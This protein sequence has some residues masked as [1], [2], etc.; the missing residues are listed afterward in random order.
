MI[1]HVNTNDALAAAVAAFRITGNQIAKFTA[2]KP[3]NREMILAHL[4]G[5]NVLDVT[6]EDRQQAEDIASYL[7]QQL[8]VS[9]LTNRKVS[10][11]FRD[12]AM[13][14]AEATVHIR[15]IGQLAWAPKLYVDSLKQD[16]YRE[17]VSRYVYSS[18]HMGTIKKPI[19]VELDILSRRYAA[20]FDCTSYIA[21]DSSG[22]LYGILSKLNFPDKVTVKGR[23]KNHSTSASHSNAKITYL[24]YVKEV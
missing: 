13:L 3:G 10:E 14:A 7:N 17:R 2:A 16:E 19:T 4:D 9:A 18:R 8:T 1:K 6:A 11:F 24:N 23:V 5:L 21:S 22:N 12:V 15:K 20:M